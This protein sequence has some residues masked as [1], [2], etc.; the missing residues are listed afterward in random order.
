MLLADRARLSER[1]FAGCVHRVLGISY[2]SK[3]Y[4]LPTCS[5]MAL[6]ETCEAHSE[7]DEEGREDTNHGEKNNNEQKP[8]KEMLFSASD[9]LP[10]QDYL[11]GVFK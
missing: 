11:S 6:C 4:V 3:E 9:R 10:L 2:T 1:D 7:S 8:A 5:V